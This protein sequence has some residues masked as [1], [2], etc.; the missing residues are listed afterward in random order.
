MLG[1]F[2]FIARGFLGG[3]DAIDSHYHYVATRMRQSLRIF[4]ATEAK[5]KLAERG[6]R[7]LVGQLCTS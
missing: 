2:T 5:K 1:G 6:A 3:F 7:P 4:V